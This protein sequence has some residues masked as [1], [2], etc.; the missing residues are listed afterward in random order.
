MEGR[1]YGAANNMKL[2]CR[3][4]GRVRYMYID[5]AERRADR[6]FV[7]SGLPVSFEDDLAKP[8]C[9][10]IVVICTVSKAREAD[11]LECMADLERAMLIEGRDGYPAFCEEIAGMFR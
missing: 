9:G 5:S 4:P 7:R 10:F 3:M 6:L 1:E 2:E 11:F 8:G